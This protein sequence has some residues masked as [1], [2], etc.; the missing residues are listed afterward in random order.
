MLSC[1]A[2]SREGETSSIGESRR[3][4]GLPWQPAE[5][6]P[7]PRLPGPG[8]RPSV[9][10]AR[11]ITSTSQ[12]DGVRPHHHTHS[13]HITPH[14]LIIYLAGFEYFNA[15]RT[16]RSLEFWLEIFD[17]IDIHWTIVFPLQVKFE[18]IDFPTNKLVLQNL[19]HECDIVRSQ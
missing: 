12:S 13:H 17:K 6:P 18:I 1:S 14:K 2:A 10:V 5:P 7:P 11:C 3:S 9:L 8:W 4:P 16:F 15:V 19:D